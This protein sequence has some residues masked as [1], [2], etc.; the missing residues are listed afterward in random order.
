MFKSEV[1]I[2]RRKELH[3]KMKTGLALFIGNSETPMNYPANT[4]HFRQD[5]DFLYFFGLDI[6]GFTGVMDFDSGKDRILGNDCDMDDI[7]WMGPQP[8]VKELALKSGVIN[9]APLPKLEE[10]IKDAL[11]KNRKIN[12]LPPYRGETKMILGSLLKENPCQMKTLA[13]VD[14]IKAVI[15]MRSIKEKVEIEEI[16]KAVD[17]AYDMHVTAMKMCKQGVKEQDIFGTIEGI[18]LAKGGGTSFPIILSVNGQTLHNHAHGNIL[19]KG[20]MM[21]TDAGAETNLHYSSDITRT[22]PVG[23]KFSQQQKDIYEIVLKANTE[24]I[25]TTRPGISNRDLHFMACKIIALG[26]KELGLMKGDV[27]EAVTAGAHALFMPH[28]LGHMMGL[29]VHDMEALG[30]NFIGYNE[31]VKRSDQFGLAFLRF[32][33]PYKQG[34]VFT[35]EP[36][37]YFIP[38]LI[39]KW[40]AEGKFREF[41]NYSKIDS[42]ISIGGIRIE[43]DVLITDKGHKVLGKPIPKTVKEVESICA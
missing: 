26:M 8:T 31:K 29:D 13:S 30:E 21:V 6:P 41:I 5:S 28:G 23:G 40:K 35:V 42:Y 25:K 15:S 12:F 32:A 37:C 14:L 22:T 1:Y 36:G 43:D 38:E 27:D 18:A 33:M 11:S 34:H 16:E 24:A 3:K 19:K 17:I 20:R 10:I 39:E 7:I 4:Y 2:K 9:T